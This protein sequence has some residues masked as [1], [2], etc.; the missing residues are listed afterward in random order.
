MPRLSWELSSV[1]LLW[2]VRELCLQ[3]LLGGGKGELGW[4][5]CPCPMRQNVALGMRAPTPIGTCCIYTAY[6]LLAREA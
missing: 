1:P 6:I 3:L 2:E 4:G 5:S